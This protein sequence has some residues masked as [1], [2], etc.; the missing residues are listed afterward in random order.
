MQPSHWYTC[1]LCVGYRDTEILLFFATQL[2]VCLKLKYTSTDGKKRSCGDLAKPLLSFLIEDICYCFRYYRTAETIARFVEPLTSHKED[3]N[4]D[5]V[6][7][8]SKLAEAMDRKFTHPDHRAP[9]EIEKMIH[10]A[11]S[12]RIYFEQLHL[13]P[14]R[15]GLTFTQEWM[16]WNT[17]AEAVMLFQFIRG[18]VSGTNRILLSYFHAVAH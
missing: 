13:H 5:E 7:W 12:G 16:E 14:V 4:A 11:N 6:D 8:V 3:E 2:F 9:K 18:M 1:R 15:I 10:L 17:G